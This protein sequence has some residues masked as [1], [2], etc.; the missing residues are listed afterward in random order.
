MTHAFLRSPRSLALA[1]LLSVVGLA[2]CKESPSAQ[3][4]GEA[5][6]SHDA[7]VKEAISRGA[8]VPQFGAPLSADVR[9]VG[10]ASALKGPRGIAVDKSGNIYVADTGNFRVV[11]LDSSGRE[12][13]S[14]GKQGA[15]PGEFSEPWKVAI[16]SD[17]N[18]L[19]LDREP[20]WIQV[21]T[22]D[23]QFRTRLAGPKMQL[24][25][26]G[27]FAVAPDGTIVIA[28]TGVS[29]LLMLTPDGQRK[30][31]LI[32]TIAGE[33]LDQPAD[34]SFDS[35]GGLHVYQTAQQRNPSLLLH[36]A[37]GGGPESKWIAVDSPSTPDSARL[38]VEPHGRIYMTDPAMKRILVYSSDGRTCNPI[39][40]EG[41]DSAQFVRLTGITLDSQGQIY[42]VDGGAN[43]IYRL[44]LRTPS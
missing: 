31:E 29:N 30:G 5:G 9:R 4:G 38:D 23:G 12:L 37:A 2:A 35:K 13:L 15:G 36:R 34:A 32:T 24:Y 1:A 42:A 11:K 7:P 25:S 14:F 19:V 41:P 20:A 44:R 22:T 27:G 43:A 26:P 28:N 16:S 39:K 17:G 18:I 6:K 8:I 40:I 3:G 21:Y 33:R 10:S